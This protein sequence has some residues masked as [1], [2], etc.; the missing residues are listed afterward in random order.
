MIK[1]IILNEN[2]SEIDELDLIVP[3]RECNIIKDF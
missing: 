2:F 1:R 3:S